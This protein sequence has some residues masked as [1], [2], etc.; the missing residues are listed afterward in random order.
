MLFKPQKRGMGDNMDLYMAYGILIVILA[1]SLLLLFVLKNWLLL[2]KNRIYIKMLFLLLIA[3]A[4]ELAWRNFLLVFLQPE[5][6]LEALIRAV[7]SICILFYQIFLYDMALTHKMELKKTGFFRFF[8]CIFMLVS[9]L[10]AVSPFLGGSW[11]YNKNLHNYNLWGNFL[12]ILT[13]L[14][15]LC[16][17]IY[18]VIRNK[19]VLDRKAYYLLLAV[20]YLLIIDLNMQLVLNTRNLVSYLA[21]SAVMVLY[22]YFFHRNGKYISKSSGC[23]NGEGLREVLSE[24]MRYGE[25]YYCLK[26]SF[27]GLESGKSACGGEKLAQLQKKAGTALKR[28]CGRHNVYHME[29][30]G[31][32]VMFGSRKKAEYMQ[33]SLGQGILQYLDIADKQI[34]VLCNFSSICSGK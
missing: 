9:V 31:Y 30:L 12:Q 3:A 15:C 22:Y 1:G 17:G 20:H 16:A 23:F 19:G 27:G 14:F 4:S 13:L 7:V 28:Y 6:V 24:K 11:F 33:K 5:A 2:Q 21:L 26:I 29:D 8:Y 25:A 10:T 34:S 32:E 18:L